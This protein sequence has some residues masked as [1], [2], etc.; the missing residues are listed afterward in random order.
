MNK[1]TAIEYHFRLSNFEKFII[2]QYNLTIDDF[3]NNILE[4]KLNPYEILSDFCIHLQGLGL[5]SSSL[6]NRVITVK[7]FLEFNDVDISPRKFKLKVKFPKNIRRIREA[8]DKNDI[9]NILNSCSDIKLKTYVMLLASTGMRAVEALSIRIKDIYFE[10]SPVKIT[11]RGEHTKT[12]EDRYVFLTRETVEQIQKW[13]DYKY[14]KRRICYKDEKTGKS[15]EE[16]RIPQKN[17]ND[18]LFSVKGPYKNSFNSTNRLKIFYNTLVLQ[19][20]KTLDRNN[21][22]SK[23]EGN[24]NNIIGSENTNNNRIRRKITLHSFRR[25]VKTTISDLGY[26]DY[27]EWFIGHSG[28]TYWTKKDNEKAEIF[29]KIEPYLTFLNIQQLNRQGADLETKIEELQD[30]NQVLREKDKM[31][32]DVIA[33]LSDKLIMLSERLDAV[34]RST[35][36]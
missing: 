1:N 21:M 30:V 13:I 11:I 9:T 12:K 29:K 33:N 15:V 25:F 28:S 35:K 31:K 36:Q 4:S 16:Y 27:S 6:K 22:G 20:Q 7:N 5:H 8:L 18:F 17:V 19:F 14:R 32:E 24:G 23:E 3:I 26:A 2:S 10:S 34:E